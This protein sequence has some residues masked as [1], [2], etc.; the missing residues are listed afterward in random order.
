MSVGG[1]TERLVKYSSAS[2]FAELRGMDRERL[3]QFVTAVAN[4]FRNNQ[5]GRDF[6]TIWKEMPGDGLHCANV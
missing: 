6:F 2:L 3:D 1:L 5:V 4:V